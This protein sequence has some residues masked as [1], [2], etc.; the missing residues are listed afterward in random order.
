MGLRRRPWPYRV[1]LGAQELSVG[2]VAGLHPLL[3]FGAPE[4]VALGGAHHDAVA[5]DGVHR[6]VDQ[7]GVDIDVQGG[8]LLGAGHAGFRVGGE[9]LVARLV[10]GL[11][12]DPDLGDRLRCTVRQEDVGIGREAVSSDAGLPRT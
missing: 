1:I 6:Q 11:V 3:A 12:G 5:V 4:E 8:D 7:V 10:A 2:E 9:H